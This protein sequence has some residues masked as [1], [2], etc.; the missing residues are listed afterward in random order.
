MA[1]LN[2]FGGRLKAYRKSKKL[3]GEEIGKIL[4]VKKAQIAMIE[5]NSSKTHAEQPPSPTWT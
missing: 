5:K 1:D 3:K 4:R 2:T